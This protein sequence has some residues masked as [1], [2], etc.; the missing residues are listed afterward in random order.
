MTLPTALQ[1]PGVWFAGVIGWWLALWL[2]SAGNPRI[3]GGPE[4]PHMDK[5]CH[6]GYFLG[7][8]GLFTAYL[9]CRRPFTPSWRT[10]A[11]VVVLTLALVGALDEWHQSFNPGRSGNDPWDW[12]ADVLGAT[13]GFLIFKRC[14]RL[15]LP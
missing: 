5:F 1:K 3:P 9:F 14:H 7:G 8:G 2:L 13:A 12:L 4:I 11:L 6:F 10:I 15:L